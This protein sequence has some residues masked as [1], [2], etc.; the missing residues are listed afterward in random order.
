MK[1]VVLS[2]TW[3]LGDVRAVLT[4]IINIL[5]ALGIWILAYGSWRWRARK[6]K[7]VSTVPLLSLYSISGIGEAVEAILMLERKYGIIPPLNSVLVQFVSVTI[8][9]VATILSGPIA[10]FATRYGTVV[11]EVQVPGFL[12]TMDHTSQIG[13]QVKWNQTV[14]RLKR[15]GFPQDQLLDFLPDNQV[16][17]LYEKT[18]WNSSWALSCKQTPLTTID[19]TA[20]GRPADSHF[21]ELR[22]LRS[23]FPESVLA[24][25]SNYRRQPAYRAF[26]EGDFM[27]DVFM[28][29]V[30]STVPSRSES[31]TV[32]IDYNNETLHMIITALHM[33][34][35]PR[36]MPNATGV[37]FG[38]GK[39]E[40]SAYTMADCTISLDPRF[41]TN[42]TLYGAYPWTNDTQ[43]IATAFPAFYGA[44]FIE[45]SIAQ[46][47][48]FHPSPEDLIRLLQAYMINKDSQ[49]RHSVSR[50]MSA[51][52]RSVEI[53]APAL[54]IL[55]AY[56]V[57]LIIILVCAVIFQFK[58]GT[59][60]M[61]RTKMEWVAQA[62]RES[63]GHSV[64]IAAFEK[65]WTEL[66]MDLSNATFGT[67]PD[68]QGGHLGISS[69]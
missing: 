32:R 15:A 33:K 38:V 45:E 19:L 48:I 63:H 20:T 28:V 26:F 29:W 58:H 64:D 7:R 44:K 36:A 51:N 60:N 13:A 61:P 8:L 31:D 67:V 62:V 9:T 53:S 21:E 1:W 34:N 46:G 40:R 52:I 27:K 68:L 25:W 56:C 10:K 24:N 5:C 41:S 49:Y 50:S 69:N 66:R 47:N 30:T 12:A 4:F 55:L 65:T 23:I 11:R 59:L 3:N 43:N 57:V 6:A 37:Y 17:W 2:T 16:D 35:V 39:I 22:G 14:D 42:G 54:G 18:Q